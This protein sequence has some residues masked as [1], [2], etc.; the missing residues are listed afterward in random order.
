MAVVSAAVVAS[1]P[2][3]VMLL[4]G[5]GDLLISQDDVVC[6]QR[7]VLHLQLLHLR[8]ECLRLA[9]LPLCLLSFALALGHLLLHLKL[10]LLVLFVLL[11]GLLAKGA[12]TLLENFV[13]FFEFLQLGRYVILSLGFSLGRVLLLDEGE[14]LHDQALHVVLVLGLEQQGDQLIRNVLF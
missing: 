11:L 5:R 12:H 8:L 14:S 4:V 1:S 9:N 6:L 7:A 13:F 3:R 10:A 2:E